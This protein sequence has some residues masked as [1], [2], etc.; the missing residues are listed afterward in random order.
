MKSLKSLFT[1]KESRKK[2]KRQPIEREKI[3]AN[4]MTNKVNIQ[5]V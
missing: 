4:D 2:M 3:F 5:N 1:A